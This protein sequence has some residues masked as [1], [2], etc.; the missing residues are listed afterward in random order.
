MAR[1]RFT[2]TLLPM[3]MLTSALS[4]TPARPPVPIEPLLRNSEP[5]LVALGA[6]EVLRRPDDSMIPILQDLVEHWDQTLSRR[7]E[8]SDRFDAMTVILDALIQRNAVVSPAAITAIADAFPDQALVLAARLPL[9]DAQPLLLSWY[10]DGQSVGSAHPDAEVADRLMRARVAAMM[11][12]KQDPQAIAPSILADSVERLA[13]SV[14]DPGSAGVERCLV[15]CD[16]API[17]GDEPADQ[18][19]A[20]WPPVLQYTLEENLPPTYNHA[21]L[22]YDPLLVEAGGDRIKIRRV[23]AEVH[24]NYCHSPA[25]LNAE[26]RHHLLAEM[27][28]VTDKQI[29]WAIQMNLTLPW[30]S[31]QQFLNEL[32]NQVAA[33]EATLRATVQQFFA[34]GL[35]TRSQMDS[36]RPRLSVTVFDDR[37]PIQPAHVALPPLPLRDSRTTC[38]SSSWR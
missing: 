12:A 1:S 20:G 25:P 8:D 35:L 19:Q 22:V 2:L 18:P 11:L 32:G 10:Q 7:D 29:P 16:A 33:E 15:G 24:L 14:T 3:L 13:V 5:R 37:Q 34:K 38:R 23:R 21:P 31:D 9:N 26:T 17:C 28:R 6:W 4:Q 27:L 30:Q 36:T